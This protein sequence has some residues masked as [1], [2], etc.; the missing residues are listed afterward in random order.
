MQKGYNGHDKM[1][2]VMRDMGI[3]GQYGICLRLFNGNAHMNITIHNLVN[4]NKKIQQV[5]KPFIH[6]SNY[7]NSLPQRHNQ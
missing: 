5:R 4:V 1:R 2:F 6:K 3:A 7:D